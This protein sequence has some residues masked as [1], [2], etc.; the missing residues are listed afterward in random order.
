MSLISFS[1][2]TILVG[3][4]AYTFS[5]QN[6]TMKISN[7]ENSIP[8]KLVT[9][10]CDCL[11]NDDA[12]TS[13]V[14]SDWLVLTVAI[15]VSSEDGDGDRESGELGEEGGA[16]RGGDVISMRD[17]CWEWSSKEQSWNWKREWGDRE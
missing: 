15:G 7:I 5:I 17:S 9:W 3:T 6:T 11:S 13:E 1:V 10:L 8:E 16:E 2:P 14:T 4:A 12:G